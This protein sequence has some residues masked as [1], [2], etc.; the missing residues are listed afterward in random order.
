VTL[1]DK[2]VDVG[3]NV[4]ELDGRVISG[5]VKGLRGGLAYIPVRWRLVSFSHSFASRRV[6]LLFFFFIDLFILA[7]SLSRLWRRTFYPGFPVCRPPGG[8]TLQAPRCQAPQGD[9]MRTKEVTKER[10][11]SKERTKEK[12]VRIERTKERRTHSLLVFGGC[13][14]GECK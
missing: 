2:G 9:E 10:V 14:E 1:A 6:Y 7:C 11:R 8:G 13:H 12:G 5:C 4:A 3:G